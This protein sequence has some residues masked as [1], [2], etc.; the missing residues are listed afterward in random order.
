MVIIKRPT[1]DRGEKRFGKQAKSFDSGN[2][3]KPMQSVGFGTRSKIV[4]HVSTFK[5]N[6][7]ML[8]EI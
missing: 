7:H 6:I 5:T 2:G 1:F 8:M 4:I 3:N